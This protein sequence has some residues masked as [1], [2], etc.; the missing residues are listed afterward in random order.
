MAVQKVVETMAK[1]K[2]CATVCCQFFFVNPP[3]VPGFLVEAYTVG[4]RVLNPGGRPV[5]PGG[6]GCPELLV[7]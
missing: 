1:P 4:V 7:G 3:L 2:K 5:A 6:P